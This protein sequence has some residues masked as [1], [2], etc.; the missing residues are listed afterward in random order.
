MLLHPR[1]RGKQRCQ[2]LHLEFVVLAA[3]RRI[4]EDKILAAMTRNCLFEIRCRVDDFDGKP[5]NLRIFFELLHRRDTVGIR[6]DER[7]FEVL[8]KHKMRGDF[9]ERRCLSDACRTDEC[10]DARAVR[11][12]LQPVG[13]LH[14]LRQVSCQNTCSTWVKAVEIRIGDGNL[15]RHILTQL[16]TNVL[17]DERITD[18]DNLLG[19]V[20]RHHG[21]EHRLHLRKL[22]LEH[23]DALCRAVLICRRGRRRGCWR[24]CHGRGLRHC[25]IGGGLRRSGCRG[26]CRRHIAILRIGRCRR[27]R[28]CGGWRCIGQLHHVGGVDI[29]HGSRLWDG[30]ALR[31][32]RLIHPISVHH[33]GR[34][35]R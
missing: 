24:L 25:F 32:C 33:I 3:P 15:P 13:E 30:S 34:Q 6:R 12:G 20:R 9:C 2:F 5:Q 23:A 18:G 11:P 1:I 10:I 21:G 29:V 7:P 28:R 14:H 4:H 8:L 31:T 17:L 19:L 26:R 35:D 27:Y 16:L 22:I